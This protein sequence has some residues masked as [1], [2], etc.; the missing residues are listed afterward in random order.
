MHVK[1]LFV[2]DRII[3][4]NVVSQTDLEQIAFVDEGRGSD[5][6]AIWIADKTL[7][8]VPV[9]DDDSDLLFEV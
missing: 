7:Q 2:V 1:T 5:D 9:F 6:P 8:M 4:N 3:I